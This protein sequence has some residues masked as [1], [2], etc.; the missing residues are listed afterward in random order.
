MSDVAANGSM[1]AFRELALQV[2]AAGL[3]DRRRNY[4]VVKISLTV[5]MLAGGWAAFVV[6]GN[7][8]AVLGVAVF[9][10][11]VFAQLGFIGHDA[12]HQQ[13]FA[14]RSANRL[15]GLVV[16]NALIG[17]SFGWWVPKHNAH[18][19][20]PNELDRDP[21]VGSDVFGVFGSAPAHERKG[22][23]RLLA[24]WRAPLF[25]P[26]L[27][28]RSVGLHVGA[29][30]DFVGRRDRRAIGEGLV[31]LAHGVAFLTLVAVVLSP[32]K[33]VAFVVVQQAVFSVYLGVSF[34]PNHKG[35]PLLS[36]GT[37][38]G[39]ADRQVLTSRNVTGGALATFVLGGLNYQIEHHLFPS[40]PRPNLRRAQVLV[41][42]FCHTSDLTYCEVSFVESF[43][44]IVRHLRA[45]SRD[46]PS[47]SDERCGVMSS[48]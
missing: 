13:I 46:D 48:P 21:D 41:K 15:V 17:L 28:L 34:A 7:S 29:M 11:V 45:R 37:T 40:M 23:L 18:H 14:S 36:A 1:V 6:V 35:M 4:Y 10:G 24:R 20:H 8:W 43:Q 25:F 31:V 9:L 22:L 2:R 3:L 12:G 44:L 16:G 32:V 38:L 42:T 39:F 26:L 5:A 47:V 30:R 27:A 33:A 19:S